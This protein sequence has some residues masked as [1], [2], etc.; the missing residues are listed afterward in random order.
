M[1]ECPRCGGEMREG[2]AFISISVP[3]GGSMMGGG[4]FP[5][6]GLNVP[7]M[8]SERSARLRWREKTGEKKGWIIKSQEEKTYDING[9]RCL[10]CGYIDFYVKE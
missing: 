10:E 7:Q 5:T 4:M 1:A 6:Q 8:E 9:R 3:S 2:I